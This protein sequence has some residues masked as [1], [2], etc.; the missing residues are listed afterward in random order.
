MFDYSVFD[1]PDSKPFTSGHNVGFLNKKAYKNKKTNDKTSDKK[2]HDKV[3]VK[4]KIRLYEQDYKMISI[5]NN[6]SLED[7]YI[8][9]YNAVYPAF[10]TENNWDVIPPPGGFGRVPRLYYVS[11]FNAKEEFMMVPVHKFISLSSFMQANP[12]YFNSVSIMGPP[13]YN[14]YAI[15]EKSIEK[16]SNKSENT[17]KTYYQKFISCIS[18]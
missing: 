6:E 4:F 9:I 17:S 5:Y 15:D 11:V 7:L 12:E 18:K 14:I 10:S 16:I 8:K 2:S 1:K 13:V 3:L